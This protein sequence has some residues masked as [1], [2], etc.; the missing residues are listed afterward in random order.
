MAATL[1]VPAS[2]ALIRDIRLP[3]LGTADLRRLI[4]LDADRLLPFAPGSALVDFEAGAVAADSSQIVT[5]AGLPRETAASALAAAAASGLDIR[6]LRLAG[7]DTARFDFL[8]GWRRDAAAPA[9]R[10][11]RVWWAI[12]AV[13]FLVNVAAVIG[14]DVQQLETLAGL[15]E[16]HGQ[17]AAIARQLRG[18][19]LTEDTRRR[20]LLAQR[21]RH[22][23][24]PVLAAATRALP[25]TVWVQRLGWDGAQLRLLGF[26]SGGVDVVAALRRVPEFGAVRSV[27]V[28]VPDQASAT[29][30][31]DVSAERRP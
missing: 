7:D 11:Q 5:I 8:P 3:A 30:P 17:T 2:A 15:V 22:D 14:R 4:A 18:R 28:D 9:D 6:Q 12:V 19:V 29:Q 16:D 20:D 13:L 10:P 1:L 24:L 31:F 21:Q 26:K 25:D 23:P 27:A